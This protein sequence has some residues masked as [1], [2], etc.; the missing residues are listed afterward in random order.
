MAH[1]KHKWTFSAHFRTGAYGLK[2]SRLACRR[3]REAT[4]EIKKIAKK[5]P[6]LGAEGAVRLM[7]KIWPA[8]QKVDTSSGALGTAVNKALDA[9]IPIIIQAPADGKVRCQW[10]DRLWQA[11]A[12][13][14]INY[15]EPVG[16]RWGEICGSPEVAGY[17]ADTLVS[18]LR[19]C[20]TDPVPGGYFHGTTACLSCL[21]ITGRYQELLELLELPRYPHW[22][23]RR[24]GVAALRYM[25]REAEAIR[26]TSASWD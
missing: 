24:Y 22:H 3:L 8:L 9:L 4:S 15:L 23:Y 1:G 20:W 7:E 6:V 2:G 21:L 26:Y 17:W 10:L 13:E 19:A 5:D 18:T 11:M 12:D 14:K 16:D 25:G